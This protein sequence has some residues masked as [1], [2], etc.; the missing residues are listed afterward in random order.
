M[1][2]DQARNDSDYPSDTD[3][4]KN[5]KVDADK[6]VFFSQIVDSTPAYH[7]ARDNGKIIFRQAFPHKYTNRNKRSDEYQDFCDRF[8]RI[9]SE[10]STGTVHFVVPWDTEIDD[11]RVWKRIEYK[12]LVNNAAVVKIVHVNYK[13]FSQRRDLWVRQTGLTPRLLNSSTTSVPNTL[14]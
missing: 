13:D 1:A 3:I 9:F 8:S 14:P 5:C 12:A 11:R 6:S 10:K 7:F 4:A 2:K